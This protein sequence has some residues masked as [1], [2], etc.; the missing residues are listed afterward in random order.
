[1]K[2]TVLILILSII[3]SFA[4]SNRIQLAGK[5]VEF[6]SEKPIPNVNISIISTQWGTTTDHLGNFFINIPAGSYS[7]KFSSVGYEEN[8]EEINLTGAKNKITLTVLL[9]PKVFLQ[10]EVVVTSEKK[11]LS[12]VMQKIN[13]KDLDKIP[14]LYSDVIRSVKIL[15][16]VTSNNELSSSYNVRGGNFNE[17]LIYL[18]GYEIFRP[19]LIGQGVEE[20]QSIINQNMV[21]DLQF[22]GGCF[23]AKLDDKMSSAL[24]VNYNNNDKE[25]LN[26]QVNINLLSTGLTLKSKNGNL[27]WM[28]AFRYANPTLFV[29]KLQTSGKY[30]PIF[31]DFQFFGNYNLSEDSYL[32]LLFI[33]ASN[34]FDLTPE[35]WKGHFQTSFM[36]AKEISLDFSGNKIYNFNS[37]L[38]GL[39][40]SQKLGKEIEIVSSVSNYIINESENKNLI[41]QVYYSEDAYNPEDNK[42]YLKTRYERTNNDLDI[43]M[44]DI[45][46]SLS[47]KSS[48]HNIEAGLKFRF[49]NMNNK[50]NENMFEAGVDSV[51][52]L[53]YELIADQSKQFN[54]FSVYAQDE[55]IFNDELQANIGIR[56]LK[57]FYNDENLF[58]PRASISY[59]YY[60]STKLSFSW[61][62]YYQPPFFFEIRD[63]NLTEQKPLL[64]Q[65]A[66]HYILGWETIFKGNNKILVELY[67]KNLD[68]LIPYS[69]ENL[70]LVYGNQNDYKGYAYGLDIQY[71]G[72]LVKGINTWIGYSYLDTKEKNNISG[73]YLRRLLD[74]THTIRIFLQDRTPKHPNFQSHLLFI[75]GSGFL[76]HPR[77]TIT[78]SESNKNYIVVNYD[79]A[80][81]YPFFLRAD[82]GLSYKIVFNEEKHLLITVDVFNVFNKYNFETY[83]WFH[84][85]PETKQPLRIPN[86]L[87]KRF[88]NIGLE[89]H[90]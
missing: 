50:V 81:E 38:I 9:K 3:S 70:K 65:R 20:S 5:V 27:N 62:Y 17:N 36:D 30:K 63:K 49:A 18:N 67:Y 24:E 80:F 15:P 78:D 40:L 86:V 22:Y 79:R 68:K 53:P 46:S 60:P 75:V 8:I 57:Y 51:L 23:P 45:E 47:Y 90:F 10:Q 85:F 26:G 42:L 84:I 82:M 58:S 1:M 6:E 61:G 72:E 4:Q 32:E 55:I 69:V 83:S 39:K 59:N 56:Y 12:A 74:Q 35:N 43:T 34:K 88:F 87:S 29:T 13:E 33:N 21:N 11:N 16:G 37:N 64:S 44:S 19:F 41:A 77:K 89:Y 48:S 52:E 76:Y 2:S 71:Q 7:I 66:I 31:M 14:N 73:E 28:G 25:Y 54:S